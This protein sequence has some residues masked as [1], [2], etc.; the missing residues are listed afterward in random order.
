MKKKKQ[1][2]QTNKQKEN[3]RNVIEHCAPSCT[4]RLTKNVTKRSDRLHNHFSFHTCRVFFANTC[5]PTG[6]SEKFDYSIISFPGF[7]LFP[8]ERTLV[9]AGHVTFCDNGLLI[10]VGFLK[11]R[12]L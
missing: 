11:T 6:T 9:A 2:Q 3:D 10:G 12:D 4:K 1:Q 8:R 5:C 7:S